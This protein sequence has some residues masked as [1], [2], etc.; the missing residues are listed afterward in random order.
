MDEERPVTDATEIAPGPTAVDTLARPRTDNR[1]ILAGVA[2]VVILIV[3]GLFLPPISLGQRLA[4]RTGATPA[5]EQ[6]TT[7]DVTLTLADPN[8]QVAVSSVAAAD[9]PAAQSLPAG[10][11]LVSPVYTLNYD[12]AAPTG[13]ASLVIPPEGDPLPTLDLYG[14]NGQTWLFIPS[15]IDAS[16][17]R[18]T[19]AQGPLPPALAL[20]QTGAVTPAVA[21]SVERQEVLPVA[22]L[23]YLTE[24]TAGTLSLTADGVL[25]GQVAAVPTGGYR[26]L[27]GVSNRTADG[28]RVPLIALLADPAAQ[29]QQIE[30]LVNQ[31]I[32]GGY[33]GVSL[34][35]QGVAA[36][37]AAAFTSF[38]GNLANV[39]HGRQLNLAVTL[40]TPV[41]QPDGNWAAT[42]QEW[43]A[44][45]Q[46]ADVIYVQL[47]LDPA[48]YGDDG[49]ANQLLA[50]ATRQVSRAKLM[51]LVTGG[52]VQ[53]AGTNFSEVTTSQALSHFGQ[54][55]LV[56]GA[57]EVQPGASVDVALS[58]TADG[59][60]WDAIALAYQYNFE[61]DGQSVRVW[62]GNEAAVSHR[63]RLAAPYKVRGVAINGLGQVSD[64]T[65]YAA[66]IQSYLGTASAPQPAGAAIVWTVK[67][68]AGA[69]LSSSNGDAL[70]FNWPAADQPGEYAINAD[71]AQGTNLTSLGSVAVAVALPPTP[72]PTPAPTPTPVALATPAFAAPA[73][74]YDP[75]DADAVTNIAANARSGPGLGYSV[76]EVVDAGVA[77]N[78]IGRSEAADW[79][80]VLLPGD[81]EAWIYAILLTVNS[82]VNVSALAVVE[83]EPPAGGSGAAPPPVVPP[84]AGGVFELG[85]QTHT[86]ANPTL[87]LSA[88]MNWVKFQHKWTPGESADGVAGL[89][90]QGHGNGFKVLLSI[91][92]ATT[93][94]TTIDYTAYVDYLGGVA[95]L[96]PDAIEVWNEMNIDFEWPAGQIDP[97]S[98]L[99]NMLAPAYNRIKAV[100]PNIMVI[101]GAP[102]PTGYDNGTNAWADDRYMAGLAAAGGGNY[103]DCVGA[104]Y[105]AGATSPYDTS[106]HPAAYHYSWYFQPTM[107]V[108]YNAFGGSKRVCWTELGYLSGE[109]FGSVPSRFSW[110]A[111]TSVAEHAQWLSE[112]AS[113]SSSTGK[114]RLMIV[115]NVDFTLWGDD[116][117]AGY[118]IIRPDGSCP[119]CGTLG[120]VMGG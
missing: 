73:T 15:Q 4:G 101:S 12:G 27:L 1:L 66:A 81:K 55:N 93:Y 68:S 24:V 36:E 8:S 62:L 13:Q 54:V 60:A 103:M 23:P 115:F 18:L 82:S 87:M 3:A 63:L 40:A 65:G 102:A 11:S 79:L 50:W 111:N 9:F 107:D 44:I 35:Y 10:L 71:F 57:A 25:A 20:M 5:A 86:L 110:A 96:G 32:S 39:L 28:Q 21:A 61:Q 109:D 51:A 19:S 46:A 83:V 30:S 74:S 59:L 6:P 76:I 75:G 33:A 112:A 56:S 85:G 78:L 84:A 94:P 47:P 77:V 117:Q 108:Y 16:N 52:A 88:G 105:N 67:D 116:P 91:P 17:R 31:A 120:A 98:Y 118:A 64:G 38:V 99:N 95:A 53:L 92:G 90:N 22:V 42:G 58:G 43:A 7:Q 80:Q 69:V 97:V 106:G 49:P 89:I 41:L 100:N 48:A 29:D 104:H 114:V 45:G 26:Q 37:Q 72:T 119:A 14:W 2:L 70:T 113:L 34:D